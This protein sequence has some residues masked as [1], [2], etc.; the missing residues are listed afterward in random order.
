MPNHTT[1]TLDIIQERL[2]HALHPTLLR[3][4]DNS[5]DH[6]GHVG[7]Q[8][9][10][11]HYTLLIVSKAFE[12]QSAVKRHQMIYQALDG[13]IGQAIHALSIQAK[14]PAEYQ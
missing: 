5:A 12:G 8:Q 1:P 10:G 7:A 2:T 4:E 14:T 3:L 9:G 11:G 6:A 13:L